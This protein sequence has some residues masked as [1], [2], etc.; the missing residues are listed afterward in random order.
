MM[1]TPEDVRVAYM[2]NNY[3][4]ARFAEGR[5]EDE[6]EATAKAFYD[7]F[8]VA[9]KPLHNKSK[10]SQLNAIGRITVFKL[11]Y[12]LSREAFDGLLTVIGRLHPD[13]HVL[14]KSMYEAHKLLCALKMIYE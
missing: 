2:L 11:Q 4:E 13:D 3:Y 8:E 1:L 6:P 10:V 12:S 5:M 7:M 9:Q 14:P